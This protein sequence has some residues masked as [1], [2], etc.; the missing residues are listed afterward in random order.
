VLLES[1]Q[2]YDSTSA[3][4]KKDRWR[5]LFGLQLGHGLYGVKVFEWVYQGMQ[6]WKANKKL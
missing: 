4:E 1:N 5:A 2:C 6:K 3:E